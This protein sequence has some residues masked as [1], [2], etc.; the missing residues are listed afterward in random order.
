MARPSP[1]PRPL[2]TGASNVRRITGSIEA[3]S[4]GRPSGPAHASTPAGPQQSIG[5]SGPLMNRAA[6]ILTRRLIPSP[7]GFVDSGPHSAADDLIWEPEFAR[8]TRCHSSYSPNALSSVQLQPTRGGTG[9]RA[10][11]FDA[12]QARSSEENRDDWDAERLLG[13]ALCARNS[14]VATRCSHCRI[15]L[16]CCPGK[17][18]PP[19]LCL[20]R[21]LDL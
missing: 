13:W 11:T 19:V 5:L 20:D 21:R 15:G 17:W 4:T 3:P 6:P 12:V 8:F 10:G 14:E 9:L 16:A 2:E 18:P 1:S 7:D